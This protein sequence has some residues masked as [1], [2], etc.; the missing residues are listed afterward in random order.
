MTLR[1]RLGRPDRADR[2][3]AEA[4]TLVTHLDEP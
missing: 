2:L 3:R 1:E 4:R